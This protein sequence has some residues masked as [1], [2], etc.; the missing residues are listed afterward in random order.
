MRSMAQ[1]S[2]HHTRLFSARTSLYQHESLCQ[3]NGQR[4]PPRKSQGIIHGCTVE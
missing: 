4:V 3:E 2:L 1:L